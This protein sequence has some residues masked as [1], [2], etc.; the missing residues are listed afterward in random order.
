VYWKKGNLNFSVRIDGVARLSGDD[1]RTR[2]GKQVRLAGV[3]H[4]TANDSLPG[5]IHAQI[6]ESQSKDD[7]NQ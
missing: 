3:I 2:D 6:D 1:Q 4:I 7:P 5:E